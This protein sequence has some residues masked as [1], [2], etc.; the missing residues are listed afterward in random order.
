MNLSVGIALGGKVG[1]R[2]H[3]N[4]V[5]LSVGMAIPTYIWH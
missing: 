1:W 2:C 3:A 4:N 5:N